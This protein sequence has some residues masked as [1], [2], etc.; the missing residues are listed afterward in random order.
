MRNNTSKAMKITALYER[1]SRDDEQQGD[2]NSIVNQKQYLADFCSQQGFQNIRH[3]TDDGFSGT[4]FER[5]GFQE[6]LGE[7]NAGHV[8]TVIVKD[9]SRF[10]RNYLQVGYYTDILFPERHVRFIAINNNIDSDRPG[11]NDF[12]PFLNIMNEWYAKDTSRKIQSIFHARMQKG[13]RCSGAVPFGYTRNPGDKQTLVVAPDEAAIVKRIFQ[14]AAE[15]MSLT[16]I[17]RKLMDDK[18]LNATAFRQKYHPENVHSVRYSDPCYWSPTAVAH[19][20]V[21]K[22]Y[23]GCTVLGKTQNTDYRRKTKKKVPAE[24]QLVFPGTHEAIIDTET[25]EQAQRIMNRC[26]K[27]T[28]LGITSRLSG[29]V[30]CADCGE[31]MNYSSYRA[32]TSPDADSSYIFQC[33]GFMAHPRRC[34]NHYIKES[35]IEK[36]VSQAVRTVMKHAFA[37]EDT[38]IADLQKQFASRDGD[39]YSAEKIEL[40]EIEGRLQELRTLSRGLYE[41]NMKGV[42]SDMMFESMMKEY[43]AEMSEKEVR[44]TE[45]ESSLRSAET[46]KTDPQRFIGL[47]KKY[48]ECSFITNQMLYSLV[49]RIEV[50]ASERDTDGKKS[51][52]ID[53]YFSF[54]PECPTAVTDGSGAAETDEEKQKGDEKIDQWLRQK[55]RE[56]LVTATGSED[57]A[58]TL[59]EES[60]KK[61]L[62]QGRKYQADIKKRMEDDPDFAEETIAKRRAWEHRRRKREKEREEDL[63]ARAATDSDAARQLEEIRAKKQRW[64]ESRKERRKSMTLTPEQVEQRREYGRKY[65]EIE[66]QRIAD[67]DPEMLA[68]YQGRITRRVKKKTAYLNE[69]KEKA[70]TDP[71]AAE[72]LAK[73]R[74][75]GRESSARSR[76]KREERMATDPEYAEFIHR[77]EQDY[78]RRHSEK[79]KQKRQ[80]LIRR[81]ET[82]PEAARELEELRAHHRD[83]ARA[84]RAKIRAE[85]VA[86]EGSGTL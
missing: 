29:L 1:L 13:L 49:D 23:L 57:A 69:L 6:L 38:F 44:K 48:R 4:N 50:H 21:R 47:L 12:T 74:E 73:I 68:M 75:A 71:E 14:M 34:T 45:L 15:G 78:E 72:E 18:V 24:Q 2:S 59:V 28:I 9:M 61:R 43:D 81:A 39:K 19:I 5:P 22:E 17:A 64:A 65:R 62:E 3:F 16:E 27:R 7:I 20:L 36:A 10:G 53:I 63:S 26:A 54:L 79:R 85:K 51:Q 58:K 11:S 60:Q 52:Q 86:T 56:D 37:D 40:K 55:R 84:R 25:W 70:L 8:D 76:A 41:K 35:T 42:L 82:D 80:D 46:E 83:L 66:R 33:S 32:R 30:Y 77:R 67:G 31:R